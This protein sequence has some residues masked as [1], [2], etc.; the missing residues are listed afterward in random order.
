MQLANSAALLNTTVA[1]NADNGLQFS[2]AVGTCYLGG[3]SGGN[4]LQLSD[5]ANGAIGLVVGGNGASTTFS[6]AISGYGSLTKTGNGMLLLSGPASY[7]GGTLLTAGTL[8]IGNG[9]T[10]GSLAGNITDN[11][12]LVFNRSDNPTFSGTLSGSGS[13]IQAGVGILTLANS[14]SYSGG[15]TIAASAISLNNAN[16]AR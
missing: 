8:Q 2:P 7:G 9:G 11:A 3:L 1:I 12:A 6:G 15:T 10:T 5:T 13:V 16:A 14:N 4:L